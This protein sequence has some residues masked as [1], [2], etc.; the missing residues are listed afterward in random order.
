MTPEGRTSRRASAACAAVCR[1]VWYAPGGGCGR[2]VP[3]RAVL[4]AEAV[5]ERP[6]AESACAAADGLLTVDVGE[7][8]CLALDRP[9][10]REHPLVAADP[11]RDVVPEA[12]APSPVS[13]IPGAGRSLLLHDANRAA[14]DAAPASLG[15]PEPEPEPESANSATRWM[16]QWRWTR[17]GAAVLGARL[18]QEAAS[19]YREMEVRG[20]VERAWG[21]TGGRQSRDTV[22]GPCARECR[23]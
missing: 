15:A 1:C 13:P 5:G 22:R 17:A 6:P 7:G 14:A 8:F 12:S 11:P 18:Q 16:Q 4:R 20:A 2:C 3:C 10:W 23:C 9:A 21:E 19:V